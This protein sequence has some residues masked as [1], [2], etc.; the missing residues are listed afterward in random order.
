MSKKCEICG[1]GPA[2]GN[3]LGQKRKFDFH[4]TET[5]SGLR[6]GAG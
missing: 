3:S 4:H 1:K 2:T 6:F 5:D